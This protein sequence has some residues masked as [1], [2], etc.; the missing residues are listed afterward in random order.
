[1]SMNRRWL[2]RM[3]GWAIVQAGLTSLFSRNAMA[4]NIPWAYGNTDNAPDQWGSLSPDYALCQ[5]GLRQSP[6]DLQ[7]NL[8]GDSVQLEFHYFSSSLT[9]LHTG[10]TIRVNVENGSY[11]RLDGKDYSLKQFHFHH[12]SEHTLQG[13]PSPMEMHFVHIDEDK[14][15]V[16]VALFLQEGDENPW[17]RPVWKAM[18]SQ[19]SEPRIISGV[20]IDLAEVLPQSRRCFR[21]DGSLTTP[22]CSEDVHWI[23]LQEPIEISSTQLKAFARL[24]PVNARPMQPL[25]KRSVIQSL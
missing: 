7:T 16:V 19:T 11:V 15:F 1:M 14:G 25:N 9:I 17:L 3:G 18:P 8:K 4:G 21:Y 12:P 23:V 20:E 13:K 24:F 2:L 10:R 6:I 22:P 5:T